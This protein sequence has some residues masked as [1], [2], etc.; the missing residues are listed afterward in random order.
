MGKVIDLDVER[1]KRNI[2]FLPKEYDDF[3]EEVSFNVSAWKDGV[4]KQLIKEKEE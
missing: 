1:W 4:W 3:V 2:T